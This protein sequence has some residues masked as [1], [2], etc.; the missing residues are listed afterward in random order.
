MGISIFS[1]LAVVVALICTVIPQIQGFLS[2]DLKDAVISIAAIIYGP[3]AGA[4]ISFLAAFIEFITFSTTGYNQMVPQIPYSLVPFDY[5]KISGA[6]SYVIVTACSSYLG[7][8]FVGGEG[9]CLYVDDF[10][11]IYDPMDARFAQYR[12]DFF[13]MFK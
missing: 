5:R 12:A 4:V 13:N 6:P 7:D 8:Y 3:I 1:A 10:D 9:S 11:F 2:L